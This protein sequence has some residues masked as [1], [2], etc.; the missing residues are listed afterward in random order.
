MLRTGRSATSAG[1]V[2]GS[3]TRNHC[4]IPGEE[5]SDA[6]ALK[7]VST[8]MQRTPSR[9]FRRLC[10]LCLSVVFMAYWTSFGLDVR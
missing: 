5:A 2:S 7:G 9:A 6:P 4:R 10:E 3:S 8:T 1:L